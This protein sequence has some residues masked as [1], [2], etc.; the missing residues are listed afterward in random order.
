MK[1]SKKFS[2]L[3]ADDEAFECRALEIILQDSF[4]NIELLPSVYNGT[5][6]L[7]SGEKECPDIIIT[8]INMPGLNGLDAIEIL[9]KKF[10]QSR[11]IINTAYSEFDYARKAIALGASSFLV[12]PLEKELFLKEI[13]KVMKEIER[14]RTLEKKALADTDSFRKILDVAGKEVISSVILGKSNEEELHIWLEHMGHTYWGGVFVVARVSGDFSLQ[15]LKRIADRIL[16][17]YCTFVT[18]IYT[19]MLILFFFP[20]ERVGHSNYESWIATL[21]S[22][23]TDAMEEE[24]RDRVRF[25]VGRWRYDYE[26]MTEAYQEAVSA[27]D[28]QKQDAIGYFET[29]LHFFHVEQSSFKLTDNL[30]SALRAKNMEEC[31]A[32]LIRQIALWERTGSTDNQIT[33]V[34]SLIIQ[35]CSRQICGHNIF[36]WHQIRAKL[37]SVSTAEEITETILACFQ[38]L[39]QIEDLGNNRVCYVKDALAFIEEN[40]ERDISL[41]ETAAKQGLSSFYLSRLLTQ[42]LQTSFVELLTSA[43]I[44]KAIELIQ[45]DDPKAKNLSARVGFQSPAY[46]YKVFKKNTGM[47]VGEMREFLTKPVA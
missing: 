46:F 16:R 33:V 7:Q 27:L 26:E 17:D 25:G 4:S 8:D 6:L 28:T 22:R 44:N 40:Y 19:D 9:R 31:R 11:V 2:I 1:S 5:E 10:V 32:L 39:L 18:K 21:L 30:V 12:K 45:E 20:G 41:E 35:R 36:S 29:N 14:E 38:N 34:L 43:R 42:W 15:E 23:L 37:L 3:I 13:V 47:T 24:D